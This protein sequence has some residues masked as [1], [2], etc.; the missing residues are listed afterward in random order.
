M[1]KAKPAKNAGL[2]NIEKK[3]KDWETPVRHPRKEKS[4]NAEKCAS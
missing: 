1:V 2:E 3:V 4:S